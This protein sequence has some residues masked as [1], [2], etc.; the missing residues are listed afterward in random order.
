M[1]ERWQV[2]AWEEGL[3]GVVVMELEGDRI[4]KDVDT[5]RRVCRW[6]HREEV[7]GDGG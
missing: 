6:L 3:V 1:G 2:L 4:S 5:V 7:T